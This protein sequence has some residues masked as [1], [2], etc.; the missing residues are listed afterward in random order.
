VRAELARRI[1]ADTGS[2]VEVH[3]AAYEDFRRGMDHDFQR[4]NRYIDSPDPA[5]GRPGS[6]GPARP[7][8][9]DPEP[10][11]WRTP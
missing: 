1:A 6:D 10:L 5:I 4:K 7:E 9:P 2:D 11:A 3:L 8:A